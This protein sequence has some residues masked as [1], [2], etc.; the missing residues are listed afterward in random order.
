MVAAAQVFA[1]PGV[2][3][4]DR[5][6]LRGGIEQHG[7]G[8][9]REGRSGWKSAPQEPARNILFSNISRLMPLRRWSWPCSLDTPARV[10]WGEADKFQ[11]VQY[12]E[13]L[14]GDLRTTLTR[15]PA[16]KHFTPEDHPETVADA[17]NDLV[18]H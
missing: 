12:G 4:A 9:T 16:G 5:V 7:G 13:R 17:I 6:G 2:A 15:I 3:F 18:A 1:G 11:R 8:G 10:V 14:A